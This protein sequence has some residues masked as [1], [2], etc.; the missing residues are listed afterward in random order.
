[1]HIKKPNSNKW[2]PLAMF[3]SKMELDT[4]TRGFTDPVY[5]GVLLHQAFRDMEQEYPH[6]VT[7]IRRFRFQ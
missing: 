1:V 6:R 5:E 3:V 2:Q 7:N 4:T